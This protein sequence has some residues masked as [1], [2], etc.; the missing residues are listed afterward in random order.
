MEM[1]VRTEFVDAT[2]RDIY[3]GDW[4]VMPDMDGNAGWAQ[5]VCVQTPKR[6]RGTLWNTAVS[7]IAYTP[8][9]NTLFSSGVC[10]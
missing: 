2:G 9:A 8:Q 1:P 3:L 5:Q 10:P 6:I 7:T 4:V